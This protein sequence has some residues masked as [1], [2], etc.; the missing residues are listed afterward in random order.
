MEKINLNSIIESVL[1]LCGEPIKIS[2]LEKIT[3]KSKEDIEK[4][5]EELSSGYQ[6]RKS[7]MILVRKEDEVQLAT[8]PENTQFVDQVVKG[9]LQESLTKTSLEVLSVVAYRGPITRSGIEAIRGVNSS[10]TLRNLLMRGLIERIGN[11]RDSRGYLYK[12]SFNFLKKMGISG[13]DE[14]PDFKDLSKDSRLESISENE[15]MD[16]SEKEGER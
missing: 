5:I 4:S 2:K 11:P 1:F 14:L 6:E 3:G 16:I 15:E 12:I 9:E 8:S 7:G 10:F 13:I